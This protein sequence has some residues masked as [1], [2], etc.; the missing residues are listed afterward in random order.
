M[1]KISLNK[2]NIVYFINSNPSF[3]R[4]LVVIILLINSNLIAQTTK[5]SPS[6]EKTDQLIN[7]NKL[8]EAY[9]LMKT[10]HISY[11]SDFF[12][13]WK[14]AQ[15][16]YWT[17]DIENAKRYYKATLKLENNIIVKNDYAKMLFAIGDYK[18]SQLVFAELRTNNPES[19]EIWG[20]SIKSYYYNNELSK[21]MLLYKELPE[22]LQSNWD[23]IVLKN[24]IAD[25]K[26]TQINLSVNYINDNQP[27]YTLSPTIRVS[28]MHNSYL[29]W[30]VEGTFN[31]FSNDTLSNNSKTLKMGNKFIFNKLKLNAELA[32]GAT[33]LPKIEE[34][35][36]IGG[37][38][39]TK[40]ITKG[41]DLRGE[42]SRNPYYYSLMST[43]DLV[44]QDNAGIAIAINNLKKFSGNIQYQK[45]IFQDDNTIS[46][47]SFWFLSPAIGT[48]I[49]N[50]KIGYAFEVMDSEKDNFTSTKSIAQI[51]QDYAN[52][53]TIEGIYVSY[54]TPQ[55]QKIHRAL[56]NIQLKPSSKLEINLQGSYGFQADW[57]NPY[58]FLNEDNLGVLFI[59]KN[60]TS[61]KFN[62]S[63]YKADLN[64]TLNKKWQLGLN[65]N[66]FKTAFYSA[67]T[68]LIN[69]NYKIIS[70]K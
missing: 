10:Y 2:N 34:N 7:D 40:K 6:F 21:A 32:V 62:P 58:L 26:A 27:L 35:A 41:I 54:F 20:Y 53:T 48:Q 37:L 17:W 8:D 64:Y 42:L 33:V 15:L 55:N 70:E 44:L 11:P 24:E 65:Y 61:E 28:K 47:M 46:A 66:Y 43:S 52:T 4:I 67:N 3:S 56:L 38:Y 39:L 19:A 1:L 25:Y 18:E 51:I 49:I 23:L 29:N 57:E 13:A 45:Q 60:F 36:V 69:L 63:Q 59:D 16:A 14:T 9:K 30:Y 31:N 22:S 12:T 68:F 5:F 50:A